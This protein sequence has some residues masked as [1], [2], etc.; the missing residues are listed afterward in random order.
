MML[1]AK[2]FI[3][4]K[5]YDQAREILVQVNHPIA[6]KWLAKLDQVSPVDN[7]FS[8][9][10]AVVWVS[11]T[12]KSDPRNGFFYQDNMVS[13]PVADSPTPAKTRRSKQLTYQQQL[14]RI[15]IEKERSPEVATMLGAIGALIGSIISGVIWAGITHTTGMEIGYAAIGI[16]MITGGAAVTFAGRQGFS[17]GIVASFASILG[18]LIGKLGIFYL[19]LRDS[20]F[21][22]M[23][24]FDAFVIEQFIEAV[25]GTSQLIPD[26][27]FGPFDLL[28]IV[29][30]VGAAWRLS[31][32]LS[33]RDS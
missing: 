11:D 27:L 29:L 3:R 6:D 30:A 8:S 32:G 23:S 22:D 12:P 24:P 13:D 5:K 15:K 16:G 25:K 14:D 10:N 28:W 31:S 20:I 4:L 33:W 19:F 18:I 2:E 1:D 7:G 26:V 9:G 21:V 17:L